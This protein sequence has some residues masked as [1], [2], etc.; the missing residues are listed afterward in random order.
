[1]LDPIAAERLAGQW[2][3]IHERFSVENV[4]V[5][6]L[7][8]AGSQ[9]R[10]ILDEHAPDLDD[11]KFSWPAVREHL[12]ACH[13]YFSTQEL[14]I[15]PLISPTW[16]HDPF[17]DAKQRIYMSAT[18]GESGDLERIMGRR[19]ITRIP[20]PAE[21]ETQGVGRRFFMFP[22]RSLDDDQIDD[23]LAKL[24]ARAGRALYILPDDRRRNERSEWVED[25]LGF[26]TFDAKLIESDKTPFT[27]APQAV[28]LVANRYDGIDLADDECRLL[29]VEDMPRSTNLQEQFI[30]E[31]MGAMA[32]LAERTS[33]RMVQA[34]GRCTRSDLDY[35]LV[36][37]RGN[38]LAGRLMKKENREVLNPELQAELFFGL[39]QSADTTIGEF[40]EY[41]DAFWKQGKEWNSVNSEIVTLRKDATRATPPWA[42]DLRSTVRSEVLYG[43]ALWRSDF[44]AAVG[45]A[46]DVLNAL[47]APELRGYRALWQ[48]LGGVAA[49]HADRAGVQNADEIA[50]SFFRE[51]AAG[52]AAVHWLRGLARIVTSPDH[53]QGSVSL[54]A[55][56][57]EKQVERIEAVLEALGGRTH[58][59]KYAA[60]EREILR[61]LE[62]TDAATFE[63]TQVRLGRLLG[64]EAG[65]KETDGAPDPWW[66]ADENL[67]FIFE[68]YSEATASSKLSITKA[69]QAASHPRWV[70]A[71]LPVT[72]A[73]EVIAVLVCPNVRVDTEARPHLEGVFHWTVDEYVA[74]AKRALAVV[75]ELRATFYDRGD[76]IWRAAAVERMRQETLDPSSLKTMLEQT[77]AMDLAAKSGAASAD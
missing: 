56:W 67:C 8:D 39:Q 75:R 64:Y 2:S 26:E 24:I 9:L 49:W 65:N 14:L 38:T 69:R 44:E 47:T 11:I 19:Q 54:P 51:A 40:L 48:Y 63:A 4:P 10:A 31:R 18:F 42:S 37:V 53:H 21:F 57:A 29:I 33:N 36:V 62:E 45:H 27:S 35:A 3:D 58:D 34:F 5:T 71:N 41:A 23:L 68:D 70:R 61:G 6:L 77:P 76:M 20:M 1:L 46:R 25:Q 66:L 22:E 28:A 30:A 43:E 74:Y 12:H 72:E 32:L 16:S 17:D 52:A 59:R 60:E 13:L 55:E 7:R 15:R 50:R 73:A